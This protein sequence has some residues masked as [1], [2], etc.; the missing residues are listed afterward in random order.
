[1]LNAPKLFVAEDCQQ[2]IWMFENYTGRGGAKGACKDFADL[3]RYMAL[4]KLFHVERNQALGRAGR[5][6]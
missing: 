5:G 2:V 6:F 3:V 1:L 4:A